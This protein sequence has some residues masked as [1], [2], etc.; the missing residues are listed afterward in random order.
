M[1]AA[2][3]PDTDCTQATVYRQKYE[4][5]VDEMRSATAAIA[6]RGQWMNRGEN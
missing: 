1:W 3:G 6:L 4:K 5:E 2:D